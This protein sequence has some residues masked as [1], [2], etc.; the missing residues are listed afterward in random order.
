MEN[1][2]GGDGFE[3]IPFNDA[4]GRMRPNLHSLLCAIG[5]ID[6]S[7]PVETLFKSDEKLLG[8][9]SIVRCSVEILTGGDW[10]GSGSRI[11]SRTVSA[12]PRFL[13]ECVNRHLRDALPQSVE[14]IILLGAEVGYVREMREFL[15]SEVMPPKIEYVYQA[16]GRTVVHLPHPSGEASGFVKVFCGEKEK[17]GQNEGSMIECRRQVVPAV[18]KLLPSLGRPNDAVGH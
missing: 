18:A 3:D 2:S 13:R 17:P 10:K 15:A 11:L 7:R 4:R 5:L 9:A 16:L 12:R 1:W 6:A 14:L 8:F